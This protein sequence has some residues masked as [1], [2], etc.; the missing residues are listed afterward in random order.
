MKN[1]VDF[2]GKRI[3]I[4][5]GSSGIGKATAILL[6]RLG[7]QIVLMS[8]N[9]E[10][11]KNTIA[12][13]EGSGHLYYKTDVYESENLIKSLENAFND[14]GSFDGLVYAAGTSYSLPLNTITP[15]KLF[16]V[17]QVNTFSFI[18]CVKQLSKR[19][20]YNPGM[21]IVGVSSV[22]SLRGSISHTLYSGSK[23]A[24]DG[25]VRSMAPELAKKGICINTVAPGMT[26]TK[27]FEDY[28]SQFGEDSIDY[29]LI[30]KRQFRG[31]C[32]PEDIAN[33]ISFLLSDAARL[34]TGA[35]VPVDGGY[36]V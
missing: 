36:T 31:I 9:E 24:M 27:M 3:L 33:A 30:N 26:N 22:A 4:L 18:E 32:E 21:R 20:R 29:I 25:A 1:L 17:F 23:A 19:G 13:L 2:Q 5:G 34:I 10:K 6:S 12:E 15:E 7:A 16:W 8:R 14:V 35:C 28:I 11:L